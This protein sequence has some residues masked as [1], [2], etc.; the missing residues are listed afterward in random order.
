MYK[1]D[2]ACWKWC[3]FTG[4]CVWWNILVCFMILRQQDILSERGSLGFFPGR[5]ESQL[6]WFKMVLQRFLS[7][8][9]F[10]KLVIAV[11][12]GLIIYQ[13]YSTTSITSI[14]RPT[15]TFV[16]VKLD[17]DFFVDFD[18]S[19]LSNIEELNLSQSQSELG[20]TCPQQ[21]YYI[22]ISFNIYPKKFTN[23]VLVLVRIDVHKTWKF[24]YFNT[25]CSLILA[26]HRSI[27]DFHI[28]M[29]LDFTQREYNNYGY[30]QNLGSNNY[31]TVHRCTTA[32]FV[33]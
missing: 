33:V 14:E 21:E 26:L 30:H 27:D 19:E 16:D 1:I 6:K 24:K 23:K 5:S 3:L 4:I 12:L 22:T 32:I 9:M 13:F 15:E 17:A 10:T 29:F 7:C 18:V 20:F 11:M 8:K 25:F 2:A 28:G 31:L